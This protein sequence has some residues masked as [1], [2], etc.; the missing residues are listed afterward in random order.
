MI[1]DAEEKNLISPGITTLVVAT[2]GNL[3]IGVAF[4]AAQKGYKFIAVMPAKIAI[5]K[6]ILLR[7]LGVEV[8]LVDP[9]INGFKGLLDRVEQLK[10]EMENVYVV[11]QFTN[12]A[13]P[14]AH[15]RW[16]GNMIYSK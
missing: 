14:D 10:N 8:I 4:V 16:T 1:E 13:N 12:P 5:D 15:F 6:Q 3:G 2:S 11:D 7:Y 9:A